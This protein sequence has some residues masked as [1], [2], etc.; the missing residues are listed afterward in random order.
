MA[1]PRVPFSLSHEPAGP[2][3]QTPR[4]SKPYDQGTPRATRHGAQQG[5]RKGEQ[6]GELGSLVLK[7]SERILTEHLPYARV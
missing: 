2:C 3:E 5:K 1:A 6:G 4:F 7:R